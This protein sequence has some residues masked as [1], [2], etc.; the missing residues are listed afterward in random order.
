MPKRWWIPG[1]ISTPL[2]ARTAA[3]HLVTTTAVALAEHHDRD[4]P[5]CFNRK[6]AKTHGAAIW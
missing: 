4:V 2:L 1:L 3:F 6:E 5:Y